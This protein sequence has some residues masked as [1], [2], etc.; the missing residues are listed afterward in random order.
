M[1][2]D[3]S[4][5]HRSARL[6]GFGGAADGADAARLWLVLFFN[7]RERGGRARADGAGARDGG[8]ASAPRAKKKKKKKRASAPEL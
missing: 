1:L 5:H 7:T 4:R 2:F 3:S 6:G 8:D